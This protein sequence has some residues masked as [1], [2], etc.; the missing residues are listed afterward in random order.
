MTPPTIDE[1]AEYVDDL[2]R[3]SPCWGDGIL[4]L[5]PVLSWLNTHPVVVQRELVAQKGVFFGV[6][7]T[8][9]AHH[10]QV[11]TAVSWATQYMAGPPGPVLTDPDDLPELFDLAGRA[12]L[13]R[14]LLAE[15]RQ[16]VRRFE[17]DGTKI[18]MAFDGDR[19]LD[20]L[21]RLL[22]LF[23]DLTPPEPR[24]WDP[25]VRPWLDAGGLDVPWGESPALIRAEFRA[26]AVS[27]IA[28]YPS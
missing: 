26:F 22:D 21:D 5:Y 19:R 16:G 17:A 4:G 11:G 2:P 3:Q 12:Y 9:R 23:D 8:A 25:R 24:A 14:N 28:N 10:N 7:M 20:A 13:M 18:V 1:F 15:V 27:L 6:M